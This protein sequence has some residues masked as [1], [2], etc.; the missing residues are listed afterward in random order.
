MK[1]IQ[2]YFPP[3]SSSARVVQNRTGAICRHFAEAYAFA[4]LNV[5]LMFRIR[6]EMHRR[7]SEFPSGFA[8]SLK[9]R[10]SLEK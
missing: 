10:L 4:K 2:L 1:A 9:R 7:G 8:L 3:Q 6:V 5:C